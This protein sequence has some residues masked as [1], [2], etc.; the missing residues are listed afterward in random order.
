[1]QQRTFILASSHRQSQAYSTIRP[2][3]PYCVAAS[4]ADGPATAKYHAESATP[5]SINTI[6]ATNPSPAEYGAGLELAI[7]QG[8]LELHER[9]TFVKLTQSGADLFA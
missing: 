1:M 4:A 5:T 6:T 7:S 3:Q 2:T 8:W 9:G